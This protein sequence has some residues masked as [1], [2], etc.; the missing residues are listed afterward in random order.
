MR[1]R[2]VLD[3]HREQWSFERARGTHLDPARHLGQLSFID[4]NVFVYAVDERDPVKQRR[5]RDILQTVDHAVISTQV[6]DEFYVVA[7]R[8]LSIPLAPETAVAAVRRMAESECVAIDAELVL[9]AIEAGTRWQ[10]SHWDALVVAAAHRSRCGVIL[11]EDL[12]HGADYDGIRIE[13]PF[14]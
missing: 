13:N 14:G 8:K 10:L 9:D 6:L 5:A 2:R 4:T 7:T 1:A 11:T 3:G 12:H